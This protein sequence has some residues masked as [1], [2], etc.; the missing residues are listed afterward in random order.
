MF[1][2]YD[3]ERSPLI[4][5]LLPFIAGI[6][7]YL[8]FPLNPGIVLT[9]LFT[10]SVIFI[11]II[12]S[13]KGLRSHYLIS[14]YMSVFMVW[15]IF[16]AGYYYTSVYSVKEDKKDKESGFLIAEVISQPQ[17]KEKA[18]KVEAEIVAIK[19]NSEWEH[20]EGKVLLYI[21]KDD[22]AQTI[23]I[24]D[25]IVFEPVLKDIEN[26]G[27]PGEFD[28]KK[29][30]AYNLIYQQAYLKTRQYY[31]IRNSSSFGLKKLASDVRKS[32]IGTLSK[33]G[34]AGDELAVVSALTVGYKDDLDSEIRQSY[35]ASGAMHVLA[36]S[37]LHV[38]II[39]VVFNF[40]L[41]FLNRN[42]WLKLLKCIL[43]LMI[44]WF[45]AFLAGLSPS[46]SRAALMFSFVIVGQQA[47]RYTNIYNTLAA[48]ALVLLLI[49]PFHIT[50]VGF[51]FSYLA[52]IG[53]VFFYPRLYALVYVKNRYADKVWGLVCVS[54]AA[55]LVTAPLGMYYF[56]Q[57][58]NYFLLTNLIVIPA[59][60]I[61]IYL[62][63]LLLAFSWLPGV[64]NIIAGITEYTTYLMNQAVSGIEHLPGAVSQGI[65]AGLLFT[66]LIYILLFSVTFFLMY[67]RFLPLFLSLITLLMMIGST[68]FK[69]VT[70]KNEKEI[71]V[72]NIPGHFALNL[73]D[74]SKNYLFT[75][76]D[77]EN[78]SYKYL[79][80]NNWAQKGL[81]K[82]K[83][84]PLRKL[85]NQF[86]LSN[87][88]YLSNP[89]LFY[90]NNC[91][92]F[93]EKQFALI[94]DPLHA[95]MEIKN[96]LKLDFVI[97][98]GSVRVTLKEILNIYETENIV[99]SSSNSKYCVKK[100][101]NEAA[102]LG[103]SLFN[104]QEKGAFCMKIS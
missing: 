78:T 27:N 68:F 1:T 80:M 19:S 83:T 29:Y 2:T 9:S 91:F 86:I 60:T 63:L 31:V 61:I 12:S 32:I 98:T 79:S 35:S 54:M 41:T 77:H 5:V 65:P 51:Q 90:K 59:A 52:V 76:L 34:I 71:I 11:V 82:E 95:K 73:I 3:V 84:I 23:D 18:I 47:A 92:A 103:I 48:S 46:I 37:G 104:V 30:L 74:G 97:L 67:R 53:I 21:E 102:E 24:G 26:K 101:E 13:V 87:L 10:S 93:H 66:V 28:Y 17:Q 49:N 16:F 62:V 33:Y 96:K 44:L 15:V 64:A 81:E 58:P 25:R 56:H 20:S 100:W 89:N 55:Q 14:R 4:R 39:F 43:L 50:N 99:I 69:D 85:N 57:F 22:A 70:V 45:Y 75:T 38:G 8:F 72:Y 42:R 36:V 6:I 7:L 94:R 40:F 88:F